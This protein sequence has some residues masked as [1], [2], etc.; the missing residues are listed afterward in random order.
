MFL[1]YYVIFGRKFD[2]V[3]NVEGQNE[4]VILKIQAK[5]NK[6]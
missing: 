5:N 4:K 2:L 3:S 1:N 6:N